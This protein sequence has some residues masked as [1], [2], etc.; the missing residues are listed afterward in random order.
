[1]HRFR[2]LQ[3]EGQR[4]QEHHR[5]PLGPR[6]RTSGSPSRC[7]RRHQARLS[8][9]RRSIHY[10]A[11]LGHIHA[12][13]EI[14]VISLKKLQ[15]SVMFTRTEENPPISTGFASCA[16][17]WLYEKRLCLHAVKF[18]INPADPLVSIS[19]CHNY[20]KWCDA[21]AA[22]YIYASN[23]S[24]PALQARESGYRGHIVGGAASTPPFDVD[25]FGVRVHVRTYH[26]YPGYEVVGY[27]AAMGQVNMSHS[28][29]PANAHQN[30]WWDWPWTAGDPGPMK[31]TCS[32]TT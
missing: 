20:W 17:M 2:P 6:R 1:M 29:R 18:E 3:P 30:C 19:Y 24:T 23:F 26:P 27:A 25:G 16:A 5:V 7:A 11:M 32:L 12:T 28:S 4:Q 31:L 22:T 10:A 8:A 15:D 9:A 21:Y 13:D 14:L